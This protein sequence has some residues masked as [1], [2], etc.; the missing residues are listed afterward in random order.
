MKNKNQKPY[1][2]KTLNMLAAEHDLTDGEMAKIAGMAYSTYSDKKRGKIRWFDDEMFRVCS[3]FN[4]SIYGLFWPEG[5]Q[6]RTA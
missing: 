2:Y 5:S 6:T 4:R 1:Y 3:H